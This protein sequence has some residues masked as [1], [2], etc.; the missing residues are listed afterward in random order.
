MTLRTNNAE[1]GTN[2]TAVTP[3]NSGGAS[4]TAFLSVSP[5]ASGSIAFSSAWAAHGTLSYLFTPAAGAA[6][7][8]VLP[9]ATAAPQFA[10]RI[11]VRLTGYPSAETIFADVQTTGGTTVARLHLTATGA[12]K[13]VNAAGSAVATFTNVLALNTAYRISIEGTVNATTGTFNADLYNLDSLTSIES[14]AQT[15]VN[16]GSTN[17]GRLALGKLTA[18][19]SMAP[20]YIDDIAINTDDANEIGP[21]ASNVAPT[22]NAGPDQTVNAFDTVTLDSTGST[23]SDGTIA[24]RLWSQ[25][26]GPAVTLSSTTAAQPTFTAPAN[27]AGASLVFGLTVTDDDGATSTQDNMAVT[28]LPHVEWL[29]TAG[30]LVP[31]RHG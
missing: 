29:M 11:Y 18:A 26:S 4:G 1:G 30:G 10:R 7:S 8:T 28:V 21:V 15:N 31:I 24:S 20:F 13:M 17:V 27:S 12:L 25:V 3:G 2:G 9:D 16:T 22:A 23:D 5:G 6:C 19:P 14:K